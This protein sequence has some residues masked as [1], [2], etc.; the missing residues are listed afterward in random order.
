MGGGH[1][2][3]ADDGIADE[4]LGHP[5]VPLDVGLGHRRV[6][7]EH[8][9]DVFGIRV[10]RGGGEPDEVAEERRDDLALLGEGMGGFAQRSAAL[11]TELRAI[12]ILMSAR[13]ARRHAGS[14]CDA[15]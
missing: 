7:R 4:L 9:I 11:F 15:G 10:L 14:L 3:D 13:G 5:A 1:P 8:P 2:E 12:A 6:R